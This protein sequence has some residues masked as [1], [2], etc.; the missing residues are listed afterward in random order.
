MALAMGRWGC[1]LE[2][3]V[4]V[5]VRGKEA[6]EGLQPSRCQQH[7]LVHRLDRLCEA[8]RPCTQA[9]AIHWLCVVP[10]SNGSP[11]A[12][13]ASIL[14]WSTLDSSGDLITRLTNSF[15]AYLLSAAD[16][17]QHPSTAF[18]RRLQQ[19]AWTHGLPCSRTRNTG[20]TT[21]CCSRTSTEVSY[22]RLTL[23]AEPK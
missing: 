18:V 17:W 11:M 15:E 8:S 19:L 4:H 20:A 1:W 13:A 2:V 10:L 12:A 23:R 22:S 3:A 7:Y 16:A 21:S 14:S 5:V 6:M 9:R